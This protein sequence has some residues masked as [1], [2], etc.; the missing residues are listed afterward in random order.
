VYEEAAE[1]TER[2]GEGET[3]REGTGVSEPLTSIEGMN[4]EA[5]AMTRMRVEER[6]SNNDDK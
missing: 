3:A 2:E 6:E 5:M 1:A 4:G